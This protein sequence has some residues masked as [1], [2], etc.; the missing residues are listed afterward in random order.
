[1]VFSFSFLISFFSFR[2]HGTSVPSLERGK[3][4]TSDLFENG[5]DSSSF[6]SSV[7]VATSP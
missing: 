2:Y 4:I 1:M 5:Y 7:F 3:T 6:I